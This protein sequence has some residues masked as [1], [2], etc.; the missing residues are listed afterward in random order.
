MINAPLT[1]DATAWPADGGR[2]GGQ[3]GCGGSEAIEREAL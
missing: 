2:A 1:T 3:P